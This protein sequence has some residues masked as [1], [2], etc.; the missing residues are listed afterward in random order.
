MD[1]HRIYMTKY[2]SALLLPMKT[3]IS[4]PGRPGERSEHVTVEALA[5]SKGRINLQ[6]MKPENAWY[7]GTGG[8]WLPIQ[9]Q[10]NHMQELGAGGAASCAEEPQDP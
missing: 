10:D 3:F 4:S 7:G 6:I 2:G 5:D 1:E 9:D 8:A